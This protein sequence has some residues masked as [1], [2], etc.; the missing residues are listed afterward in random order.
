MVGNY[1]HKTGRIVGTINLKDLIEKEKE[2]NLGFVLK[3]TDGRDVYYYTRIICREDVAVNEKLDF[4]Y[5]FNSMTFSQTDVRSLYSY[6]EPNSEGDNSSFGYVN[7]H[8][9]LN[10][11]GW[12]NMHPRIEGDI[13]TTICDIGTSTAS[14]MLE[15]MV[16]VRND[17]IVNYYMIEEFYRIRQGSDRFIAIILKRNL[18]IFVAAGSWNDLFELLRTD[19]YYRG[20]HR[21]TRRL[22]T[23]VIQYIVDNFQNENQVDLVKKYLPKINPSSKCT[24]PRKQANSIIGKLI[25]V[26]D[27]RGDIDKKKA[28]ADYRSF[29]ASGKAHTWEQK[30]SQQ[31]YN[32]IDF[33][34][35]AGRALSKLVNSKFLENHDLV[36]AY[37]QWLEKQPVAKFTGYPYE[38]FKGL[39]TDLKFGSYYQTPTRLKPYQISTLNKQFE[40]LIE[41][42]KKDMNT[43]TSFI[44][45]VDTSGS[46]DAKA[47][48]TDVESIEVAISMALYFSELLKGD[49]ANTFL[50]F[51][52]ETVIKTWN[53]N[54][55]F[56]KWRNT[57][58]SG[59][60]GNTNFLSIAELFVDLKKKGYNESEFPTG[61]ICVSDGEFDEAPSDK[62]DF[63]VFLEILRKGGFSDKFV[64]NFKLVLWD[65]PNVY[66]D[67]KNIRP[68][69][70]G[71]A[72]RP[73]FYYMTGFDPAGIAFLTGTKYSPSIPKTAEDLFKAALNQ[74]LIKKIR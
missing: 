26:W 71:I 37:Y 41:T 9:N 29:K 56:E 28:Y 63:E 45:C 54:T 73:N 66:Y 50:E 5:N 57:S 17:S 61:V 59:E 36:N 11:L 43:E 52:E 51:A 67:G 31:K 16:S 19:L 13:R 68:K 74:E 38:L 48:G 8:S 21:F 18:D 33:S 6:M 58:L 10:Q 40:G 27:K 60:C 30:I 65:I 22:F 46:M 25:A 64:D 70:E 47:I 49:F 14:V 72:D 4:I 55:P 62:S 15:Y 42:A 23:T 1:E 53:G 20:A 12:G 24:T 69:F 39:H 7:I 32:E 3:L 35:I 44:V 34:L 2:Y